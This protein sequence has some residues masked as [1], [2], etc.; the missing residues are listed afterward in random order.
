MRTVVTT[1]TY[2]IYTSLYIR[3]KHCIKKV[4]KVKL[5]VINTFI[6]FTKLIKILL[7]CIIILL[8]GH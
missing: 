2:D 4:R 7:T 8:N 1:K 3:G 5:K 6:N